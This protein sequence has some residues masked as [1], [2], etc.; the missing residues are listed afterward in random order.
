MGSSS[1]SSLLAPWEDRPP[2]WAEWQELGTRD[3]TKEV[4]AHMAENAYKGQISVKSGSLMVNFT[5][6]DAEEAA[7]HLQSLRESEDET[8]QAVAALVDDSLVDEKPK[9][10]K[11]RPAKKSSKK[12]RKDDDDDDDDE[13]EEDD[14]E[15][16]D[17][18]EEDEKPKKKRSSRSTKSKPKSKSK[19][20]SRR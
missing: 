15:D 19:G 3:L 17:E 6:D 13:D 2:S 8:L 10:K 4:N 1:S 20:K 16:E 9:P 18:D 7:L 14:D 12:S 5:W 11:K